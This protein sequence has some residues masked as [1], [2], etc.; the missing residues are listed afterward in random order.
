MRS[1]QVNGQFKRCATGLQQAFPGLKIEGGP[2]A[3]SPVART[4]PHG[5]LI[6]CRAVWPPP[7]A[8]PV[9]ARIAPDTI[10]LTV[11]CPS[12]AR[13]PFVSRV[14]SPAD[15]PPASVQ[16]SIRA[17]RAAQV[18]AIGAFFFGEAAFG[19]LGR[20]PP[21]LLTQ[22]HENKLLAAGGLY[23][24]DVIAQT[25]KAINAFEGERAPCGAVNARRHAARAP[26]PRR[27]MAVPEHVSASRGRTHAARTSSS[28]CRVQTRLTFSPSPPTLLYA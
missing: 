14:S 23:G 11:A 1:R 6:R 20:R 19:K 5:S 10:L 4:A 27:P 16:Y 7:R 15:T 13:A 8:G 25:L 12:A 3:H 22:L 28:V 17:V 26:F 2:C 21:Q 18:G 9:T 24:L